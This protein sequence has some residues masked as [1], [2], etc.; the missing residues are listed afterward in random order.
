MQGLAGRKTVEAVTLATAQIDQRGGLQGKGKTICPVRRGAVV[1]HRIDVLQALHRLA[2]GAGRQAAAIAQAAG[3]VD[4]HQL[5]ITGQTVVLHAV[6]TEDQVQRLAGQ[7]GLHRT[8]TVRVDHQRHAAAL[9]DQQR[10]IARLGRALLGTHAPRQ[11]R[12]LRAITTADHA[13]A[14]ALLAAMLD[15]P[16]DH[17][18]L[19]GTAD[20]DVSHHDHRH[21]RTV[22]LAFTAEKTRALAQHHPPIEGFERTQQPQGRM[23]GVP[24][25]EQAI[26][27]S[28]QGVP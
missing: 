4:Q 21:W 5:Q 24:G 12:R 1:E 26:G 27:K 22:T 2:Q 3:G 7:Q 18:G 13:D 23:P 9:N 28:H 10:L 17:R 6:I 15:Q 14:Q 11:L 25:I 16:E 20:G 19:A 8:R